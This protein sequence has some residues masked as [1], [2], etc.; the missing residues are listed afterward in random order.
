MPAVATLPLVS[1]TVNLLVSTAIPALA[2]NNPVIVDIPPT[3]N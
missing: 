2:F 3:L 1:A